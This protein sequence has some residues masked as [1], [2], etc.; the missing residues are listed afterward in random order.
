MRTQLDLGNKPRAQ[1]A[2]QLATLHHRGVVRKFSGEPYI[3]HPIAV[4]EILVGPG[5]MVGEDTIAAALLHDCLE[6]PDINGRMMSPRTI[7]EACGP[8]VLRYVQL[9]SN[10]EKG[11]PEQRKAAAI[12]RIAGASGI[13]RAVKLGDIIHNMRGIADTD[14]AFARRQLDEKEKM[15]RA[16]PI[17]HSG[18]QRLALDTIAAEN[19][20]LA[21]QTL[22]MMQEMVAQEKREVAQIEAM[23]AEE[24]NAIFGDFAMF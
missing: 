22:H 1:A 8:K 20:K 7:E 14:P 6:D 11:T 19:E 21:L 24:E 12:Q 2:L 17:T 15:V 4:A 5:G 9:L 3:T 13:V 23:I 10:T 16:M 18:L